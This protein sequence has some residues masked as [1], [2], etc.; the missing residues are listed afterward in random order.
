MKDTIVKT[1]TS[2]LQ[3]AGA[4]IFQLRQQLELLQ[5][6]IDHGRLAVNPVKHRVVFKRNRK[7][8]WCLDRNARYIKREKV[9]S[10]MKKNTFEGLPSDF[11]PGRKFIVLN[12]QA[13]VKIFLVGMSL[14]LLVQ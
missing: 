11:K 10:F 2:E 14:N 6:S 8:F 9:R 4:E 3:Q 1:R 12:V 5:G 13:A 7:S